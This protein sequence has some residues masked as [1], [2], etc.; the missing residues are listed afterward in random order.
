[1][2]SDPEAEARRLERL[3]VDLRAQVMQQGF[4]L[5]RLARQLDHSEHRYAIPTVRETPWHSA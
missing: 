2:A 1:M 5:R 4:E 3:I